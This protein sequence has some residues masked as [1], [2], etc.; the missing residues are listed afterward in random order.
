[1]AGVTMV[2]CAYDPVANRWQLIVLLNAGD[3][4]TFKLTGTGS[5]DA[6]PPWTEQMSIRGKRVLDFHFVSLSDGIYGAL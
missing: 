3:V 6:V 4:D 1:M 5:A 2:V